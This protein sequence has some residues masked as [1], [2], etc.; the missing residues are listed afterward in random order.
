MA[1]IDAR[2]DLLEPLRQRVFNDLKVAAVGRVSSFLRSSARAA[3][4]VLHSYVTSDGASHTPPPCPGAVV[5]QPR[6]DG[7]GVAFDLAAGDLGVLVAADS[8]WQQ[9]W[10][11]G[12]SELPPSGQRHTYG[13]AALFPGGRREGDGQ[14]NAAGSMRV[15]AEDGSA[16]VDLTRTRGPLLGSVTVATAGPTASVRLG[17]AAASQQVAMAPATKAAI[18]AGWT[19]WNTTLQADATVSPALKLS[20]A[21]ASTAAIAAVT[22]SVVGSAKVV[23]DP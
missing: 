4:S 13:S 5:V 9:Q 11:G 1:D 19:A 7:Y 23:V 10:K 17:S 18:I 15:G 20:F 3:V 8:G 2:R 14:P 16:S 21:A 12:A 22:A 6:G